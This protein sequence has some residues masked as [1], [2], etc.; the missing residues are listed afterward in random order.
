[1]TWPSGA[2]VLVFNAGSSS[3]KLS[4]IAEDGSVADR[5]AIDAWDGSA[6]AEQLRG[7]LGTLPASAQPPAAIGHRVVHGGTLFTAPQLIDDAVRAGIASLTTLAP[8]HQPRALA[9]I[10]AATAAF[11]RLPQVACFDTA[12]HATLPERARTYP[13]PAGWRADFG[14]RKYGFHGLSHRYAA[15][16][17]AE[18]LD[19]PDIQQDRIVTCHLGAGSSLAAVHGGRSVETTMGFTPVDG[20]VMATR[21]GSADPGMIAWLAG[22]IPPAELADALEHRSGLAALAELSDGSGDYRDVSAA[23]ER[24][25]AA[26]ML[27][28]D[29]HAHRLVAGIAAMAAAMNGLDAL[30]FT[31][32]IGEHA[33]SVRARAADGLGF[34]GVAVDAAANAAASSDADISADGALM[35]TLV[36][37]A[38]EDLEIARDVTDVL[39]MAERPSPP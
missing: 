7:Y 35:R 10:D 8:L 34:L 14:L 16:R 4:V 22:R 5:R 18:L 15:R 31:G 27:A 32:G 12:F 6:N 30:V 29:V 24:G 23:A 19:R 38:R 1:M 26:A 2:R 11:P 28:L 20:L 17:A 33:P 39:T 37:T 13:L 9:G 36:V 3:L 25:A 21:A